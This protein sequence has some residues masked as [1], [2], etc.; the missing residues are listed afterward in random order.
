MEHS[1]T[2]GKPLYIWILMLHNTFSLPSS[3][4]FAYAALHKETV[5]TLRA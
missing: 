1:S 5:E 2:F 4:K 3:L